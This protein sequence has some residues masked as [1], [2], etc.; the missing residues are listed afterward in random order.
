MFAARSWRLVFSESSSRVSR[1]CDCP[2]KAVFSNVP[3]TVHIIR[4]HAL[5]EHHAWR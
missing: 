5:N 2:L 4:M 1:S 3:C